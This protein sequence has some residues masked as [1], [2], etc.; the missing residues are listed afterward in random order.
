[1]FYSIVDTCQL[2]TLKVKVCMPNYR[3]LNTSIHQHNAIVI[4]NLLHTTRIIQNQY[5][6]DVCTIHRL[7]PNVRCRLLSQLFTARKARNNNKQRLRNSVHD[8]HRDS[9]TRLQQHGSV[10]E[11]R[12]HQ[13][14]QGI[15]Y[16]ALRVY[17]C[18]KQL[19]HKLEMARRT[20]FGRQGF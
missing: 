17:F 15:I 5:P 4:H 16:G 3:V 20:Q 2:T 18:R 6:N 7:Y 13:L 8:T 11:Y 19:E 10:L 1:M 9:D 12:S 14:E